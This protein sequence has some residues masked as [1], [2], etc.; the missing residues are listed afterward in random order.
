MGTWSSRIA[1]SALGA[2]TIYHVIVIVFEI[3]LGWV[4]IAVVWPDNTFS[5]LK[6]A[7]LPNE[8][9]SRGQED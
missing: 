7:T 4:T 2:P 8:T 5:L 9:T 6:C 1:G 3:K